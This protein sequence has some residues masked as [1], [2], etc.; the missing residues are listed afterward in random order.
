[1]APGPQPPGPVPPRRPLARLSPAGQE[2]LTASWL[3][4]R[5]ASSTA[6]LARLAPAQAGAVLA[7]V[8]ALISHVPPRKPATK[9]K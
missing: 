7:G 6:A 9:E 5:P 3:C 8:D 2:A 4:V 1:M